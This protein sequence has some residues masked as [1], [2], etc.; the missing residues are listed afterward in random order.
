LGNF[1]DLIGKAESK[2]CKETWA[3]WG[4]NPNSEKLLDF[5]KN[6]IKDIWTRLVSLF[7]RDLQGKR[8]GVR[9]DFLLEG[10]VDKKTDSAQYGK[11]DLERAKA[12]AHELDK[13]MPAMNDRLVVPIHWTFRYSQAGSTRPVGPDSQKNRRVVVCIRWRLETP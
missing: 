9:V 11:L 12:V 2:P 3:V 1:N 13:H 7:K 6:H 8:A 10:H 5:Q 4:F